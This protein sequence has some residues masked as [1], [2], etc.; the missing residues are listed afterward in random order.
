MAVVVKRRGKK[1]AFDDKKVYG[2]VYS[3]CMDCSLG[4]KDC[5]R[6]AGRMLDEVRKFLKGRHEV[7]STE[8]FGFIMQKLAKE[9]E[10]VAF[11]Y[12]THRDIS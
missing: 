2:S 10:A 1:E 6:I 12:E 11:M 5:E 9:H 8:I 3:A 7:N 4:E